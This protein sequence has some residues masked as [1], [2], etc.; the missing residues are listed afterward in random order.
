MDNIEDLKKESKKLADEIENERK[1]LDKESCSIGNI[2]YKTPLEESIE[3]RESRRGNLAIAIKVA[4]EFFSAVLVGVGVGLFLDNYVTKSPW[5]LICFLI[6][7]SCAG[8]L[9]VM[10]YASTSNKDHIKE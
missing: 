2:N 1:K 7:G 9:N 6:L 4:S 5:G 10:R 3:E 8:V